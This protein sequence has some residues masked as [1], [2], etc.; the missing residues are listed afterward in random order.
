MQELK[1]YLKERRKFLQDLANDDATANIL[2][3]LYELNNILNW[4][5]E[6]E[7]KAANGNN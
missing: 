2:G 3:Q 4:I 7:E 1:E 6:H 5:N